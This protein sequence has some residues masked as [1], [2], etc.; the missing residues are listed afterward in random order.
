MDKAIAYY[1]RGAELRDSRAQASL[2]V[3]VNNGML[4][5]APDPAL[6]AAALEKVVGRTRDASHTVRLAQMAEKG[7]GAPRRSR[8]RG[9]AF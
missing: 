9:G 4:T 2:A 7:V 3:L 1:M 8:Q 6:E 5:S